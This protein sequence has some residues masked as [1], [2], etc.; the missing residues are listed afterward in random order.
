M[1]RLLFSPKITIFWL[2][3]SYQQKYC[4]YWLQLVSWEICQTTFKKWPKFKKAYLF[5]RSSFGWM[6]TGA[7]VAAAGFSWSD[8]GSPEPEIPIVWSSPVSST[9]TTT[10]TT[11]MATT[12]TTMKP[13]PLPG[14][15]GGLI[16]NSTFSKQVIGKKARKSFLLL[17]E[18]GG[19]TSWD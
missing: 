8:V 11:T 10:T 6:S 18:K 9:T 7:E 1:C 13:P 19:S 3:P 2:H 5:R 4:I 16:S 14:K 12:A 17:L 15:P